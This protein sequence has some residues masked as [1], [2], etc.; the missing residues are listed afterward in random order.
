MK[1]TYSYSTAIEGEVSKFKEFN[2][3]KLNE[4]SK[5]Y[6]GCYE[7]AK[8]LEKYLLKEINPF[9][10]DIK[11]LRKLIIAVDGSNYVEEYNS[12]VLSLALAYVY[13]NDGGYQERYLPEISIV[14]PYYSTLVN[15][16][17][18]KTLEYQIVIN[19]LSEMSRSPD[20][21]LF[22]G[23]ISFPD[24]L[25]NNNIS[26]G[27]EIVRKYFIKYR[28][29]ANNLFNIIKTRHI[30]V[31]GLVKD[32]ISNKYVLSL[33]NHLKNGQMKALRRP[34]FNI[35]SDSSD[36]E[37]LQ[38]LLS[39]WT[40]N[41]EFSM[42]SE[43]VLIK[44]IFADDKT[45][46]MTLPTAI[47]GNYGLRSEIP[48]DCLKNGNLLGFYIKIM[49]HYKAFFIEI[50]VFFSA[51]LNDIIN[52]F[53]SIC[54]FS[55]KPGY[56]MPLFAAH[57]KVELNKGRTKYKLNLIKYLVR[58]KDMQLYKTIFKSKFHP[59]IEGGQ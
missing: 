24:E 49:N 8:H 37:E 48:I 21:I 51:E 46:H 23:P 35:F 1:D 55:V 33:F 14:P 18:M 13:S 11:N 15:S 54:Y 50:P 45:N 47:A 16:L 43:N 42:I 5:K 53:T 26:E 58:M 28:K 34:D 44:H 31:I 52:I 20:L 17:I 7:D 32:S 56:P 6:R 36:M 30:P 12:I 29:V 9:P 39:K 3:N 27:K 41:G 25:I 59:E 22:D 19:I 10:P 2:Y 40:K 4:I 38:N 57:K